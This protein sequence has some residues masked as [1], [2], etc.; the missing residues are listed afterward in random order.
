[1]T[2]PEESELAEE[3]DGIP[4]LADA[5]PVLAPEPAVRRGLA[6]EDDRRGLISAVAPA[7]QVAVVAAGG[8]IAGAAIVGLAGRRRRRSAPAPGARGARGASR[9]GNELLQIVGTRSLLVDVH[10]LGVPGERR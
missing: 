8:F 1:M 10:L 5:T 7:A 3:V 2:A 9:P 6:H 4:V